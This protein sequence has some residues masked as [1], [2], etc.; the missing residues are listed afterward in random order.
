VVFERIL[1][2]RQRSVY[3]AR[4]A[5]EGKMNRLVPASLLITLTC[6]AAAAA[7]C[8]EPELAREGYS[9]SMTQLRV[10]D[11]VVDDPPVIPAARYVP[12]IVIKPEDYE[13]GGSAERAAGRT[14]GAPR[15]G[16]RT[17][18]AA[19]EDLDDPEALEKHRE[20]SAYTYAAGVGA[21]IDESSEGDLTYDDV[22]QGAIGDCYLV[23]ALSAVLF[24]DVDRY[25][26]DGLIREVQDAN[27]QVTGFAVRFYD[28]WGTPQDIA[29]DADLVRKDG[30]ALYARS[31]DTDSSDEEWAI[32]LIEK[33]YA[34]W[35]G[36][37]EKIG[38]GGYAGDMM[39]ALTGS[40]ASWRTIKYLSDSSILDG[41][42]DAIE[43][44]R[45]VVAGTFGEDEEVDYSGT[46]IYANHAYSV[47]GAGENDGGPFVTLR[48]PWGEVEPAGNGEDDGI[49]D[50]PLAEFRRLYQGLTFGGASSAD[51]TAPGAVDDL[52]VSA[53]LD[54]KA[55]VTWTATGDDGGRGL[56][57]AY[58]L[59]VSTEPL[60]DATFYGADRVTVADPQS[61]GAEEQAEIEGLVPGT[62]Y[63]VAIR[64]ED[65]SGNI[66]PMSEVLV[67][68]P[69][70]EDG[71]VLVGEQFFDFE[72]DGAGW[73]AE[74]LFHLTDRRA[75]SPS[76]SFWAGI[77]E[78]GNYDD[79][80]Q[81]TASLTSPA[82]DLSDAEYPY[83]LWEQALD[84][85][86]G[87][88]TDMAWLEVTD[89]GG[90]SWRTVWSKSSTSEDFT[91]AEADLSDFAG[92]RIQLRFRFDSGDGEN[93][94][95]EGWFVDDVWLMVW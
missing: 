77:E 63:Y 71:E 62:T 16:L 42:A 60:D 24:T 25:V 37:Y 15:Y 58:D 65:E 11:V 54:Q 10:G 70:E 51:N 36:G 57:S 17:D 32:S 18:L 92:D 61:P 89:D 7:G 95:G 41:I 4:Q 53:L 2:P 35:H 20:G 6:A 55:L 8:A 88:D 69:E 13:L 27:G 1:A 79:G 19:M 68:T 22:E 84:V 87:D 74:G 67:L 47:L 72:D 46:N 85:E 45:A 91:L 9:P 23:A 52:A 33:A 81:V 59:R 66:S 28:A 48:N 5:Q 40:N 78:T 86:G 90:E 56:A 44:N 64:V 21:L 14:A 49:F 80:G 38:N 73:E 50:L 12:G 75:A 93:N 39:Q 26:R 43:D 29:V 3:K 94:S 30:K 83:L 34:E 31:M 76:H 82:L